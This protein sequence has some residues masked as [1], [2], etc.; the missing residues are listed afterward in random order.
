MVVLAVLAMLFPFGALAQ[1]VPVRI[2]SLT[3]EIWPEYDRPEAL[4]ILRGAIAPDVPLPVRVALRLPAASGGPAA[5]AYS[6]SA[7]ANLLN[8]P[9]EVA[10]SGDS[11]TVTLEL[12][13][14]FFHVEFYEP[15]AIAGSARTYRYA[16]PG[17][18]AVGRATLV[19]QEP[20]SAQGMVVEPEVR[21]TS[22]GAGGL[23]YRSGDLGALPRGKPLAIAVRYTKS[24]ARPSIDIKGLRTSTSPPAG[25][26][27]P[28][29]VPG[30]PA[31]VL[32]IS[33]FV[34]MGLVAALLLFVIWR[35]QGSARS[36]AFCARCGASLPAGSNYCGKCGAKAV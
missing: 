24:D 21:E 18:I 32:P 4:V 15:V 23:T 2:A 5:V 14:R 29:N 13:E 33:A 36:S 31:W 27:P 10:K 6:A 34:A 1:G 25:Q 11:L 28:A 30:V 3:I 26:V 22:S 19:V 20:A 7:D 16:W 9:H 12:P 17:D 35:R 8:L